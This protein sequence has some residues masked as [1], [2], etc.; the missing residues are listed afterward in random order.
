MTRSEQKNRVGA[1]LGDA[2][3]VDTQDAIRKE[4]LRKTLIIQSMIIEIGQDPI[5]S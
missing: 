3:A 5:I 2:T 1:N 4:P